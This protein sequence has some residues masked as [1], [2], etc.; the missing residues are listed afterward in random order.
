MIYIDSTPSAA[1]SYSSE[2]INGIFEDI[3]VLTFPA[4][5]RDDIHALL[6][7]AALIVDEQERTIDRYV[8]RICHAVADMDGKTYARLRLISHETMENPAYLKAQI[9]A[10]E[11]RYTDADLARIAAEQAQTDTELQLL[12]VS[13]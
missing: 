13:I 3:L 6:D 1:A 10:A 4:T 8:P 7:N 12:E 9:T 2:Q 5:P 11:Q